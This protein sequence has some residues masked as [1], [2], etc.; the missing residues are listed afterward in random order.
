MRM[1]S[2]T[3]NRSCSLVVFLILLFLPLPACSSEKRECQLL[4][5]MLKERVT[6]VNAFYE[7]MGKEMGRPLMKLSI[8][9][10][11]KVSLNLKDNSAI[12]DTEMKLD[13]NNR[14]Q[15]AP[16]GP[17]RITWRRYQDGDWQIEFV[18][19]QEIGTALLMDKAMETVMKQ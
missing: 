1:K 4:E 11:V 5:K 6:A 14:N 10:P 16:N 15:P 19:P 3:Q 7:K 9:A 2:I 8:V 18:V 13:M 17:V 12:T